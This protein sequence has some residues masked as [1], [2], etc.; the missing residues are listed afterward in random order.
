MFPSSKK[1]RLCR[2]NRLIPVDCAILV[3]FDST[4]QLDGWE[5]ILSPMVSLDKSE[6]AVMMV[7]E[8]MMVDADGDS[9]PIIGMVWGC[10]SMS[11]PGYEYGLILPVLQ[12]EGLL[13]DSLHEQDQQLYDGLR[14]A[15]EHQFPAMD[16][17][18]SWQ[19]HCGPCA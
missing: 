15:H 14:T 5:E 9:G 17:K 19:S 13:I 12:I 11:R 16:I 18:T 10:W 4:D 8:E 2:V 3:S 1:K 6:G 7:S